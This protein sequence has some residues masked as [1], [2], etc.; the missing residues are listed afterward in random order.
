MSVWYEEGV[1]FRCR[2]CGECCVDHGH[3]AY[4]FLNEGEENALAR[5]MNVSIDAFLEKY[6]A[7]VDGYVALVNRGTACVFLREGRCGVYSTRPLQCRTWPFWPECLGRRIWKSEVAPHCPG[8]GRGKL[9]TVEEI[10]RLA[11]LSRVAKPLL[12]EGEEE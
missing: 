5:A 7:D 8:I 1:R 11:S 3:Y 4:V 2:G 10:D 12:A 6:T 9:H